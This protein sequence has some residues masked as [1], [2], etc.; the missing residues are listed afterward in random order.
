MYI[1]I[2]NYDSFTYNLYQ[3]FAK[4]NVKVLVF[5]NDAIDVSGIAN[6]HPEK[7][8]I[9]PGPKTPYAAGISNDVVKSFYR[10]IP[11]LGICLGFQCIGVVFN[12]RLK[13]VGKIVHGKSTVIQHNNSRL[14]QGVPNP[15]LVAR[16]HS[17]M[18]DTSEMNKEF[19]FT[20]YTKEGNKDICMGIEHKRY[21]LYGL[22]FH[23]ESFL[24]EYG[25]R[26]IKN[27]ISI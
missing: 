20:A 23:P 21:P 18:I 8:I 10:T 17:L 3:A 16:Y 11:I 4:Q 12:G 6:L 22:L 26:I 14:F 13:K 5:R 7:I 15:I 27:F 24:T 19:E 1:I 25:D 9:S 2:D